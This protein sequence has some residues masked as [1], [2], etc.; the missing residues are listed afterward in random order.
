M[1]RREGQ[2]RVGTGG[3][4]TALA[5]VLCAVLLTWQLGSRP[6]LRSHTGQIAEIE[7]GYQTIRV[8]RE[9]LGMGAPGQEDAIIPA[10][11]PQGADVSTLFLRHDEDA[12]T[13]QSVLIEDETK[14]AAWMTGGRYFEHMAIGAFFG[15]EPVMSSVGE[16]AGDGIGTRIVNIVRTAVRLGGFGIESNTPVA[17]ASPRA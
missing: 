14:Q 17:V 4:I 7:S 8:V 10:L 6:P 3:A 11:L 9:T 16:N 15:P 12:E 5:V 2:V 1:P 13:Y